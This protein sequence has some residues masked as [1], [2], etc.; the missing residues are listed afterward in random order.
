MSNVQTL[1]QKVTVVEKQGVFELHFD[2]TGREGVPFTVELAFRPG[3][4]LSG[5]VQEVTAAGNRKVFLLKEGAG[6]VES[7][8]T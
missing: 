4:E 7:G 3:G 2:I 8:M 1:D 5:P 6:D